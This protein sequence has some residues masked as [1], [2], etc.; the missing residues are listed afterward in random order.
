ML[1]AAAFAVISAFVI[2]LVLASQAAEK[3]AAE[4]MTSLRREQ[5]LQMLK[6]VHDKVAKE[7]YDATFHGMD[8]EGRYKEATQRIQKAESFSDAMGVIAWFLD[9]LNDSHTI[10]LPPPR[11]FLVEDG[12]EATFIG[13]N[14]YITAIKSG[15]DATSKGLKA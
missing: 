10:F 4:Q 2:S 5:A 3:K 6:D 9:G 12:W 15:S 14:C 13:D 8:F 11:P 1:R 7:Y